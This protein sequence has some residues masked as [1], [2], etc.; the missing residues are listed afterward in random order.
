M[1]SSQPILR[2]RY[3][4]DPLDRLISQFLPGAAAQQRFYCK[5]RLS[6][7]IQGAIG[8]SIFQKD[9]LLLAQQKR[10]NDAVESTLLATD[11]QRSVLLALKADQLQPIAYSPYGHRRAE[12]GLGSLLGFNGERSDP[13]TGHYLLGNGYRAFNPV[14]MRF[15]S[16]DS[17]SPFG[18]GGLNAYVYCGSDPRNRIDTTGQ[19]WLKALKNTINEVFPK[20]LPENQ[21]LFRALNKN[22]NARDYIKENSHSIKETP[23]TFFI[24]MTFSDVKNKMS[25]I[26]M[27]ISELSK[28]PKNINNSHAI[29]LYA[30]KIDKQ[31]NI[32]DKL[33]TIAKKHHIKRSYDDFANIYLERDKSIAL[34]KDRIDPKHYHFFEAA[35]PLSIIHNIRGQE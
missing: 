17:L 7:E 35:D 12:S 28:A 14:L 32:A 34:L 11:L 27:T 26:T 21:G 1:A 30:K 8:Y 16:P 25:E 4:Y 2:S 20:N 9:D 19:N 22:K 5:S 29:S 18:K 23:E 6:T 24:N 13:V 31:L 10:Q 33:L 3:G 15:N